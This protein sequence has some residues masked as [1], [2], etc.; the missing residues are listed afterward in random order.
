MCIKVRYIL[1]ASFSVLLVS[2]LIMTLFVSAWLHWDAPWLNGLICVDF[3][4]CLGSLFISL[5]AFIRDINLSLH[6]LKLELQDSK[7]CVD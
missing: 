7:I 6:A 3:I 5:T 2:V 1:F 4:A